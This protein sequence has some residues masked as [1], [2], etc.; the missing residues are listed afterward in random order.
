MPTIYIYFNLFFFL[1]SREVIAERIL[2]FLYNPDETQVVE[3]PEEDVDDEEEVQEDL[4]AVEPEKK[5]NDRS[6]R[7]YKHSGGRPK[8]STVGKSIF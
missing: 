5:R 6:E 1:G 2:K 3:N 7:G 4:E 8:R